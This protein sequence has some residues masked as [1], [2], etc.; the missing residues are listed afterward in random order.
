MYISYPQPP[1]SFV[2]GAQVGGR[3]GAA[4]RRIEAKGVRAG[5]DHARR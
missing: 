5:R 1:V 2:G 3:Q 4:H